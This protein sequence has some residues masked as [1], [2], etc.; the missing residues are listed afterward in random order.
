[1][2]DPRRDSNALKANPELF[3][4]LRGDYPFRREKEAYT[5]QIV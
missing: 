2:Y 5:I 3:E 1:M 4:Q